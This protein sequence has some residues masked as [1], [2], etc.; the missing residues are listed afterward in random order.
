MKA[1]WGMLRQA[2]VRGGGALGDRGE[3]LAARWLK[4]RGYRIVH[5]KLTVGSDEADLV[6]VD[7]DGETV[8]IVEVKTRAESEPGPEIAINRDKQLKLVRLAGRLL[9]N[10]EYENH[11]IRFDAMAIIWPKGGKPEVRHYQGAFESPI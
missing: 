9:Q 4:R 5:R 10:P 2:V 7:P 6:A 3:R 11:P 8:V 1:F